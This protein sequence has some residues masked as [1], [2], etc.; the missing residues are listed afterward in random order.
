MITCEM[1]RAG[2]EEVVELS[3]LQSLLTLQLEPPW[4]QDE[5]RH[6]GC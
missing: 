1:G 3:A 2:S 6:W 4:S 5:H